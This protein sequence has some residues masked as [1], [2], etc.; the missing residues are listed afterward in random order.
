MEFRFA[1]PSNIDIYKRKNNKFIDIV[2]TP[3]KRANTIILDRVT[4][5]PIFEF[6][7][8]KVPTSKIKG[9]KTSPY[10]PDLVIPEPFGYNEFFKNDFWSYD[11]EKLNDIYSK[12]KNHKVGF[13]N[14]YELNKKNLQYNFNGGA[15]W[16]GASVD[17]SKQIMYV[18]SNN[19]PWETSVEQIEDNFTKIPYY[20]SIFERALDDLDF[21]ITKPP[22]GTITSINLNYWKNNMANSIW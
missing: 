6:R 18:T 5:K 1:C 21:P 19:I 4:G 11:D 16:M 13:Y 8:R 12:Y 7:L 15:E 2:L 20:S 3:T 22:W 14:T 17:H 10:Q 9:E